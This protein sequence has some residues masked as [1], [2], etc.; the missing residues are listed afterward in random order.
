MFRVIVLQIHFVFKDIALE[1]PRSPTKPR[2]PEGAVL[3]APG[4]LRIPPGPCPTPVPPSRDR[5]RPECSGSGECVGAPAA[6]SVRQVRWSCRR[7]RS[8]EAG[9]SRRAMQTACSADGVAP[10]VRRVRVGKRA[11]TEGGQLGAPG[12]SRWTRPAFALLDQS[13]FGLARP[14][15]GLRP[16]GKL[17]EP[18]PSE[19]Q[20]PLYQER[21]FVTVNRTCHLGYRWDRRPRVLQPLLV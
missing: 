20:L 4:C 10:S 9:R 3:P 11:S 16:G 5:D 19:A 2:E 6:G 8:F 12:N 13:D 14:S 18:F 7:R 17:S 15:P 21:F 1:Q